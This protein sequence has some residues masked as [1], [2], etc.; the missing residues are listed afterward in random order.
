MLSRLFA[1]MPFV[2]F[3]PFT[4]G[5]I[6]TAGRRF[7]GAAEVGILKPTIGGDAVDPN[8]RFATANYRIAKGLFDHL[9]GDGEYA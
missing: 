3:W 2:S 4:T 9:V 1:A 7:W 8:R 6:L 5:H